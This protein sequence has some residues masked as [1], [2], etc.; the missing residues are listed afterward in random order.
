MEK[1]LA[2]PRQ[3]V[4]FIKADWLVDEAQEARVLAPTSLIS[5]S[6]S[7]SPPLLQGETIKKQMSKCCTFYVPIIPSRCLPI[8]YSLAGAVKEEKEM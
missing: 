1:E 4:D 3:L 2:K 5:S 8:C 6:T 7:S